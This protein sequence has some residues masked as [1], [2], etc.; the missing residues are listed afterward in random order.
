VIRTKAAHKAFLAEFGPMLEEAGTPE[1]ARARATLHETLSRLG[2]LTPEEAQ[3]ESRR[4]LARLADAAQV[5]LLYDTAKTAG[6]AF[7]KMAAL[8]ATRFLEG[9]EYPTW[10]MSERELWAPA[11]PLE[12]ADES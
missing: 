8:Y 2:S 9:G 11:R 1:A 7:A 5:A 3:W 4:A 10:A 12:A 6:D